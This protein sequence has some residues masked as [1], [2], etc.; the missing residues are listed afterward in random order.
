MNNKLPYIIGGSI[1]LLLIVF[2]VSSSQKNNQQ[3]NTKNVLYVTPS[4]GNTN[5]V[6]SNDP[7]DVVPGLYKNQIQ[8]TATAE[9]FTIK[10]VTVENNTDET[11]KTVGD[12]LELTIKNTAGRDLTDFEVYYTISDPTTN[13]KEGYYKKL[14]GFVLKSGETQNVNFDNKQGIGHFTANKNSIYYTSSDKLLFDVMVSTPRYKV[15]TAQVAKAAGGAETK[16]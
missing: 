7:Q 11:G 8:N 5:K 16:D 6:T 12:H 2:L 15:Q 3:Q 1:L 9:G 4:A 10:A 14:T 13:K